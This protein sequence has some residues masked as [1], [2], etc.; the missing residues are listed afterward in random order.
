MIIKG[1]GVD[2][3]FQQL[4]GPVNND[5]PRPF[6][7][8]LETTRLSKCATGT[9][10]K[11]PAAPEWSGASQSVST[12]RQFARRLAAELQNEV[13]GLD[14]GNADGCHAGGIAAIALERFGCVAHL[15]GA[16][17]TGGTLEL[18]RGRFHRLAVT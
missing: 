9:A 3:Y 5:R 6:I 4:S 7:P 13:L 10:I 11:R 8:D 1:I 17:G 16:D 12:E 14:D 18:V 2:F 15:E